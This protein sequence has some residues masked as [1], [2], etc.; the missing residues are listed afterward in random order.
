MLGATEYTT[1]IDIWST[2]CVLGELLLGRP[3]F[4]GTTSVDQLVKIIQVLGTPTRKQMQ[5]MNPNYTEF[6]FPDVRPKDWRTVLGES[7][8][9]SLYDDQVLEEAVD[10]LSSLLRYEPLERLQPFDA[11][12]HRFFDPLRDP[13]CVLP[14]CSLLPELFNFSEIEVR[15]MSTP[16]R[17]TVIPPWTNRRSSNV[18]RLD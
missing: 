18:E 15:C 9:S 8:P 2:G 3:L 12:A 10:L 17:A 5:A 16:V 4:A 11:L 7:P 13:D 14:D 1:A 6:Q